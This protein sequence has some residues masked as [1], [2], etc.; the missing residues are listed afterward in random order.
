MPLPN[1][2]EISA[3]DINEDIGREPNVELDIDDVA[4]NRYELSRP[5]SFEEFWGR[6]SGG[7]TSITITSSNPFI[8]GPTQQE[9][10]IFYESSGGGFSISSTSNFITLID[11]DGSGDGSFDFEVDAQA[12]NAAQRDGTI[13]L[14]SDNVTVNVTVRQQ[15]NDAEISIDPQTTLTFRFDGTPSDGSNSVIYKVETSPEQTVEWTAEISNT[16]FFSHRVVN[17]GTD[18]ST[19]TI[20]GTGDTFIE[21]S[22]VENTS[23]TTDETGTITVTPT[24]IDDPAVTST[25]RVKKAPAVVFNPNGGN[26]FPDDF[27]AANAIRVSISSNDT[28]LYTL[29]ASSISLTD[30]SKFT[31]GFVN[32]Q[33]YDIYPTS[34]NASGNSYTTKIS[35]NLLFYGTTDIAV[36]DE[37]FFFT[38]TSVIVS[39]PTVSISPT[40][41]SYGATQVGA[42]LLVGTVTDNGNGTV[43][44]AYFSMPVNEGFELV[45]A[46][47]LSSTYHYPEIYNNGITYFATTNNPTKPLAVLVQPVGENNTGNE[48]STTVSFFARNRVGTS[49]AAECSVT[50]QAKVFEYS[51]LDVSGFFVN[52]TT[53]QVTEPTAGVSTAIAEI[54]SIRYEPS[55]E[56]SNGYYDLVPIG[57]ALKT[58]TAYITWTVNSTNYANYNQIYTDL[59]FETFDQL[60]RPYISFN[61]GPQTWT[62]DDTTARRLTISKNYPA[63]LAYFTGDDSSWFDPLR[64]IGSG[65]S[66]VDIGPDN[67]NQ[68]TTDSKNATFN[69]S[70]SVTNGDDISETL[71]LVQTAKPLIAPTVDITP[72]LSF[73]AINYPFRRL[74]ATVTDGGTQTVTRLSVQMNTPNFKFTEWANSSQRLSV[75]NYGNIWYAERLSPSVGTTYYVNVIP[76]SDNTDID[77]RTATVDGS[78]TNGATSEIDSVTLTQ[79]GQAI[80]TVDDSS[81]M[82]FASTGGDSSVAISS[83]LSWKSSISGTGF[84]HSSDGT[85]FTSNDING[86]GNGTITVRAANNTGGSR[87]GTLTLSEESG[88]GKSDIVINLSQVGV[89]I[90]GNV[91]IQNIN[92]GVLD[93]EADI[94]STFDV[95]APNPAFFKVYVITNIETTYDVTTVG[96]SSNTFQVSTSPSTTGAG[97][98]TLYGITTAKSGTT[99]Q[100]Y[101]N[102]DNNNQGY[103]GGI[104][105]SFATG[106]MFSINLTKVGEDNNC[107]IEGT[108]ITMSDGSY[109]L[110]ENIEVGDVLKSLD[111]DEIDAG[112]E[113]NANGWMSET[114]NYTES[115]AKVVGIQSYDASGVYIFNK[116]LLVST[117]GHLHIVKRNEEYL[118]TETRNVKKGDYLLHDNDIWIEITSIM[119]L[120]GKYKVYKLDV[121]DYD[122]FFANNILTHNAKLGAGGNVGEMF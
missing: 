22:A 105:L 90:T 106:D 28:N 21:I 48:L 25:V 32:A 118:I 56:Y 6:S 86:S 116:T 65:Y 93:G 1:S 108:K 97:V 59:N 20:T 61:L 13:T 95:N 3:E 91:Y 8:V 100:F 12:L 117:Y 104:Y 55:G 57:T 70:I 10:R 37:S 18:F 88:Q 84:T 119:T 45:Q 16:S 114:F 39:K 109:K 96:S 42:E 102:I 66:Y 107:L 78:A 24:N 69:F 73:S 47:Q 101:I 77:S 36:T 40:N 71:I 68:S 26:F 99:G 9:H 35:A 79:S 17:G 98:S 2:G 67:L 113:I 15:D 81:Q 43:S 122:I 23:K 27:G 63:Q 64:A 34:R 5:H 50:Q 92:E 74:D 31:L 4:T 80:F 85:N 121:E 60:E 49:D 11:T 115:T 82:N 87:T 51:D 72:N 83:N 52:T 62:W 29:D 120:K 53:G 75:T 33:N 76:T 41:V 19:D 14:S 7:A 103:T 89:S 44:L 94:T 46:P 54:L 110:I 111:V 30:S 38:Q 58:R 112:S